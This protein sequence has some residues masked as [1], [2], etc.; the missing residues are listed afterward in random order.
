[1]KTQNQS[2][3]VCLPVGL[4]SQDLI[5]RVHSDPHNINNSLSGFS[6]GQAVDAQGLKGGGAAFR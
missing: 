5:Y 1:M 3:C 6:V 2:V 4:C